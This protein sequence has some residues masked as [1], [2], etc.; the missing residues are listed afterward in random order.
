MKASVAW[1]FGSAKKG[2]KPKVT[3]DETPGPGTYG[4]ASR[5]GHLSSSPGWQ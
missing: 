5:A 1:S 3:Y 4:G 2:K